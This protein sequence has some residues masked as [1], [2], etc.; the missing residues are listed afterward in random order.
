MKKGKVLKVTVCSVALVLVVAVLCGC[1]PML[2]RVGDMIASA[3]EA[4]REVRAEIVADRD[5]W[6]NEVAAQVESSVE[7]AEEW[8]ANAKIEDWWADES[9]GIYAPYGVSYDE[10]NGE[11]WFN[12]K[13]IAGLCDRG[14]NTVTN[15]SYVDIGAFV[16]IERDRQGNITGAY[17]TDKES[18]KELAHID[19][20]ENSE[21]GAREMGYDYV[22]E[23]FSVAGL[24]RAAFTKLEN[25]L[26]TKYRNQDVFV[27]GKDYVF[28]F[29]KE[30]RI[31]ISSGCYVD[32]SPYA[33]RVYID[34]QQ[35]GTLDLN[36]FDNDKTDQIVMDMLKVNC[37]SAEE[38][39]KD[40]IR[41]A[42]AN[43]YGIN[44]KYVIVE[45]MHV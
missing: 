29:S 24:D 28:C 42:V 20:M 15:S 8:F 26:R 14:Y 41:E 43:T 11:Y 9:M 33:A 5:E 36:Q 34:Y 27:E 10:A 13:P 4:G 39:T 35:D 3:R 44:W 19:S 37:S 22:R 40:A 30:D 32:I 17:E 1:A 21:R 25:E 38:E 12:G 31:S 18:F 6:E 23:E 2:G 16:V 7:E 45:I